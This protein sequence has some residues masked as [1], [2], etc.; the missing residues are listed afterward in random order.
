MIFHVDVQSIDLPWSWDWHQTSWVYW[1]TLSS[2]IMEVASGASFQD[3]FPFTIVSTCFHYSMIMG[4]RVIERIGVNFRCFFGDHPNLGVNPFKV[5]R[6]RH[7]FRRS[8]LK[9]VSNKSSHSFIWNNMYTPGKLIPGT[10]K[11]ACCRFG[12]SSEPNIHYCV[13]HVN[14]QG[15]I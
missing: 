3:L 11:I 6:H 2:V 12:R 13:P 5:M 9:K 4:G 10:E 15:C 8:F 7:S 1:F 14:F